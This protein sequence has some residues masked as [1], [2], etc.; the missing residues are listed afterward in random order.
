MD[1]KSEILRILEDA[2]NEI[3]SNI[4]AS[5]ITA[6]GRTQKA[7]KVVERDGHFLLLKE[8][9]NNAPIE[10]LESGRPSG[11]VPKNFNAIILEW[12]QD[13]GI[14]ATLVPY[15][16]NRKHKYTVEERSQRIAAA[17]IAHSIY[18][19]GTGRNAS[20]IDNIYTPPVEKA[21]ERV[22]NLLTE[23]VVNSIKNK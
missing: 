2:K 16:T 10:T 15:L 7:I 1:A 19:N 9:G 18:I 21:V 11:K 22:K 5:G 13:K 23:L 20:P 14:V 3:V 17:S 4:E 12:M 8:A 6:S